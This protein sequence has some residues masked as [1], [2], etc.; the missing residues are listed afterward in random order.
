MGGGE[1]KN[2][3]GGEG[4]VEGASILGIMNVSK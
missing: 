4:G 1:S 3:Q 2:V